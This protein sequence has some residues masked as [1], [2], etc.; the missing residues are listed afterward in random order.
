VAALLTPLGGPA[1]RKA[2]SGNEHYRA[3]ELDLALA[4]YTEAQVDA[5]EAAELHYDIGNVLYRQGDYAGAAEAFERALG[6]AGPALQP[7]A[8]YNLGNAQFQQQEFSKAAESYRRALE[9]VPADADAKRNLELALRALEQAS[10]S[11][12]E[13]QPGQP[14]SQ[15]KQQQK[16]P[17]NEPPQSG[18]GSPS[19]A[20]SPGAGP[21]ASPSGRPEPAG[22]SAGE[23]AMTP[24][25]AARML[26]GVADAERAARQ[27]EAA[28]AARATDAAREK[29][30]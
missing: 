9:A 12:P 25:Q 28:R 6:S 5:P 8:A 24:E 18:P 14:E 26:D 10:R 3:G 30:W 2:E 15:P 22:G 20:P 17:Q 23:T 27:E 16:P 1:H 11:K 21:G 29:D 7:Q 19:P 4:D 13:S